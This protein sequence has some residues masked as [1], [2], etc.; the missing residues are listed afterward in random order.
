MITSTLPPMKAQESFAPPTG[1][2]IMEE[3]N[4]TPGAT[5]G[6]VT[7]RTILSPHLGAP[8]AALLL[9]R[10]ISLDQALDQA[11]A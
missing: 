11:A 1:R 7:V 3:R 4:R 2:R 6:A 5:A 10:A 8:Q 9:S